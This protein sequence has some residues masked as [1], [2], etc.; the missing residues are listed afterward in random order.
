MNGTSRK[1]LKGI[2]GE[3][4]SPP[5]I[6]RRRS[7]TLGRVEPKTT[8]SEE[9]ADGEDATL[10]A[11]A[12]R[13]RDMQKHAGGGGKSMRALHAK[14]NLGVRAMFTVLPNLPSP[15]QAGL[16]AHPS[17]YKAYVRFSN[18]AGKRQSDKAGD[19]RGIAI[20][21]L[22]VPGKK[23]IP[24]LEDAQTQDFLMIRSRTMPF[25][26]VHEFVSVVTAA[27]GSPLVALPKILWALGIGRGLSLLSALSRGLGQPMTSLAT[28]PYYS[29]APIRM[30]DYAAR[31]QLVPREAAGTPL[32][33]TGPDFLGDELAE[34]L[35]KGQVEYDFQV[36]LYTDADT[37]PIEDPTREWSYERSKPITVATLTLGRLGESAAQDAKVSEL[38]EELSF[39]PWHAL[40]AHKPIGE[41]MRARNPAYRLSTQERNA[42]A[43][44]D[45]SE[46]H[47]A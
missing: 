22:G 18:G 9:I 35:R 2:D 19:V 46:L 41:L 4:G 24:G 30:G 27:A 15:V 32:P 37:T 40:P 6:R 25:R 20:K 43:E 34:R 42:K 45:G 33:R 10:L 29:P 7:G 23:I 12:E 1:R 17:T 5:S 38:I 31:F 47:D 3:R 21:V 39:D 16:F 26:S 13:L 8:W 44:P 36:Q 28:T 14:G 11:F